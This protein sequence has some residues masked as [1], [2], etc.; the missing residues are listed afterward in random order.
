MRGTTF[1]GLDVHAKTV[2]SAALNSDIGEI[3]QAT[4]SAENPTA[5]SWVKTHSTDV[6]VTYEA[7]PTGYGLARDLIEQGIDCIIEPPSKLLRAPGDRV[8][9]DQRDALGLARMLSLG[10]ITEVRVPAIAQK[11][12]WDVSHARQRAVGDITHARQRI[13][14]MI[15]QHGLRYPKEARWTQVHH[16]WLARQRLEPSASQQALTAKLET[17]TLLMAHVKCLE[18]TIAGLVVESERAPIIDALM[19]SRGISVTAGFGLAVEIGDWTRFTGATIGS[20]LG[21][22]RSEHSSGQSRSQGSIM[23]AGNSSARTLLIEAAWTHARP[24]SRCREVA[25][26]SARVWKR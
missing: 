13:N 23:K 6:A 8:K 26:G 5:I 24:Y 7:G 20:Y 22:T 14:A 3:D 18:T 2:T 17:E 21:L 9:T 4:M 10:E 11:G 15:L 1:I 25:S 16:D 19:S 12:L